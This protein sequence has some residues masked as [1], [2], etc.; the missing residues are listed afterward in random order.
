M[1]TLLFLALLATAIGAACLVV[2]TAPAPRGA[3]SHLTQFA[4]MQYDDC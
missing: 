1:R 2:A 3:T 4:E